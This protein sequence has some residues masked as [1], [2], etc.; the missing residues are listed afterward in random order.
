MRWFLGLLA[1]L[2]VSNLNAADVV[3]M[4]NGDVLSGKVISVE[5]GRIVIKT[6][7]ADAVSL[8]PGKIKSVSMDQ[9]IR[10]KFPNGDTLT[11]KITGIKEGKMILSTIHS[12]DILVKG[13]SLENTKV[14]KEK[15]ESA[16]KEAALVSFKDKQ[17]WQGEMTLGGIY[18]TGNNDKSGLD[19]AVNVKRETEMDRFN[20]KL[21]YHY[22]ENNEQKTTDNIYAAFKYDYFFAEKTYW[23]LST[24]MLSDEFRDMELQNI[25]GGG[26]GYKLIE[27]EK[28]KLDVESGLAYKSNNYKVA[29]DD[30]QLAARFAAK[31]EWKMADWLLFKD[32]FIVYPD[33]ESMGQYQYR[34]E[35]S[36]EK[37]LGNNWALKL[38]NT[39]QYD[40]N[41]VLG[42]EAMDVYWGLGLR[43]KF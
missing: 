2:I 34:N 15:V 30:S 23:Y 35:A 11:G 7:Y 41:P 14:E 39:L 19:I 17:K 27:Q 24:E 8:D 10:I 21:Q 3:K 12:G 40:S 42:V 43:Y 37:D 26:L 18:Q 31:F 28:I 36:I 20:V 16:K 1:F 9:P 5:N 22:A 32:H 38:S 6:A 4:N 29:V 25:V 33:I 13:G